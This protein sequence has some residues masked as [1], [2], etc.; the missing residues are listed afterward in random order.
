MQDVIDFSLLKE[1]DST[2]KDILEVWAKQKAYSLGDTVKYK[3]HSLECTTAG[4]S[5]TTTLDFTNKDIGDTITDGTVVWT[6]IDS[7][8]RGIPY[9]VSG[10][11]Y[12]VNDQVVYND[13]IYRCVT[14]HTATSTFNADNWVSMGGGGSSGYR[15]V[16]VTATSASQASPSITTL[17][18]T[19]TEYIKPPLDVLKSVAGVKNQSVSLSP[20]YSYN[21]AYVEESSGIKEKTDYP[22]DMGI[23]SSLGSGYVSV[24]EQLNFSDYKTGTYAPTGS[25]YSFLD[26][27]SS[28]TGDVGGNLTW[29][30]YGSGTPKLSTSI[31]K[32]GNSSLY[33]DGSCALKT[34]GFDITNTP[35]SIDFWIYLPPSS[36]GNTGP[37]GQ[38]TTP[39]KVCFS[40][41]NIQGNSS[42]NTPIVAYISS[43]DSN[44]NVA[45]NASLGT[46]QINT[47]QHWYVGGDGS[48]LYIARNGVIAQTLHY[49]GHIEALKKYDFLLGLSYTDGETYLPCYIDNFRINIGTCLWNSNFTV[50]SESDYAVASEIYVDDD[51]KFYGVTSSTFSLLGNDWSSCSE[52]DKV[53]YF[54]SIDGSPTFSE[55]SSINNFTVNA[56]T[57]LNTVPVRHY[58]AVPKDQ[59]VTTN[60]MPISAFEKISSITINNTVQGTGSVKVAVTTNGTDYYTYSSTDSSWVSVAESPNNMLSVSDFNNLTANRWQEFL[61][62]TTTASGIKENIGFKFLLSMSTLDDKA[63]IASI[64]L[65]ADHVPSWEAQ[66]LGTTYSYSYTSPNTVVVKI[67]S[68]GTYRVNY[69]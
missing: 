19:A 17:T 2:L 13:V 32:F 46:V 68:D 16:V 43:N 6:M 28:T 60:L 5:G 53:N 69:S 30:A 40:P 39:Y 3:G 54:D 38:L 62:D 12:S 34:S 59:Y 66:V 24:S 18:T 20:N 36:H 58:S 22:I 63:E 7:N 52:S 8:N 47:W 10:K 44:W 15:Q 4:T 49:D 56:Y 55:L 42:A 33:L 64:T 65:V 37:I 23:P 21:S 14:A 67:F 25:L 48:T 61:A 9:Y 35:F 29:S 57:S 27:N 26:F 31:K 51:N 50:P 41:F 1:Y 11:T 45:S